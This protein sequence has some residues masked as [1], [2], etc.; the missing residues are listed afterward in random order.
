MP[1]HGIIIKNKP[2]HDGRISPFIYGDFIEF[3]DTLIP[4]MRA[5]LVRNRAFEGVLTPA[6]GRFYDMRLD[7]KEDPWCETIYEAKATLSLDPMEKMAG[8]HALRLAVHSV[9]AG[10]FAGISQDDIWVRAGLRY[11]LEIHAKASAEPVSLRVIL[12]RPKGPYFDEYAS[13]LFQIEGG[14]WTEFTAILTPWVTDDNAVLS[15]LLASEGTVW[16]DKIS[17]QPMDNLA[18]WR[19]DVIKAVR[20]LN[21]GMMR[22]G[23]TSL[24]YYHWEEG[25]GPRELRAPFKNEPWGEIE[26]NDVGIDEFVEFT[27]LVEC[28]PLIC[29]NAETGTPA[30]A[31]NWV[32]YCNDPVNTKYGAL[33]ACNGHPDP[34]AIKFWQVGNELSG[35]VYENTV[36]GFCL[37]MRDADPHLILLSSYPSRKLLESCGDLFDYVCPHYY[38]KSIEEVG[39]DLAEL[40]GEL[41]KLG[42]CDHIKVGVTEW[43]M[44][45]GNWGSQRAH[46]G[47][48]SNALYCARMFNLFHRNSDLVG[49]ANRSNLVN[50]FCGGI[51]RTKGSAMCLT[52]TY[53]VQQLY[54]TLS[55]NMSLDIGIRG[56]GCHL[57]V[58]ATMDTSAKRLAVAVIN[59]EVYETEMLLSFD[60]FSCAFPTAR[61]W[62]LTGR[63]LQEEN[64]FAHPFSLV[65]HQDLCDIGSGKT[66]VCPGYS[67]TF[68]DIS[69]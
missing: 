8:S 50:S 68:L 22:F 10:G 17:L 64:D 27:R 62:V 40:R 59:P 42:L 38:D 6:D 33:R 39:K 67:L 1:D 36:R 4:G 51:I 25:I 7:F 30:E 52:P 16:L 2:L 13:C 56:A 69:M 31:A 46:L 24:N 49:M 48:L 43:N 60:G 28:E 9:Q 14:D 65:P 41:S 57:D 44:T 26:E 54:A 19:P 15:M 34:Y 37:A 21:P 66:V 29:I 35:E 63:S 61:R 53:Y 23:G 55:G 18:G 58:S 11:R 3:V 32:R 5:E 12:G 45:G 20:E 47:N